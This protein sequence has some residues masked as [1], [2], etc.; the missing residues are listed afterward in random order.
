MI[1][2]GV[3]DEILFAEDP[4]GFAVQAVSGDGRWAVA[5][6]PTIGQDDLDATELYTVIDTEDEVR[7]VDNYGGLGYQTRDECQD[8]I[9][10]FESGQAEHSLRTRP[11]PLRITRHLVGAAGTADP[12]EHA[13]R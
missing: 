2:I 1:Q 3:G 4:H 12:T 9:A 5:T 10:M 8:A 7:G 11:I 13:V 6:R